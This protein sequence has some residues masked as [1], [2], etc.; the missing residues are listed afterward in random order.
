M[1]ELHPLWLSGLKSACRQQPCVI[2]SSFG[3]SVNYHNIGLSD[4][5]YVFSYVCVNVL[6]AV[7]M[8]RGIHRNY[9]FSR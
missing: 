3:K 6:C 7:Y 1:V 2:N 4:F 8:R 5:A 9:C